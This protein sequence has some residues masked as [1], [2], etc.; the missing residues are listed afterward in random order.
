MLNNLNKTS[1][2]RETVEYILEHPELE[3]QVCYG[4]DHQENT[5]GEQLGDLIRIYASDTK[6]VQRTAEVLIHEITHHKY[7]IGES[8]W[9]ESVCKAQEIKHKTNKEKLTGIELRGIIKIVEELYPTLP[10]R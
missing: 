2:G 9:A 8:Q 1:I 10:W 3:I 4:V 5:L 6:T 7:N